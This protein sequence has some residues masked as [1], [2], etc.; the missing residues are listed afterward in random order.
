MT[1]GINSTDTNPSLIYDSCGYDIY[2][3]L[4]VQDNQSPN[5]I[6]TVSKSISVACNPN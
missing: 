2:E 3:T 1:S 5:C 4:V 6:D